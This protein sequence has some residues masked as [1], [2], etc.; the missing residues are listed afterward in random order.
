MK[1]VLEHFSVKCN[2]CGMGIMGEQH[3]FEAPSI[4]VHC[5]NPECAEHGKK[6]H[7]PITRI[8]LEPYVE[9]V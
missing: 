2:T 6:Y 8:E 5:I 7:L 3:W 4:I 1:V 9:P